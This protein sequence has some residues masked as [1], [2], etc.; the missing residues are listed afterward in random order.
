MKWKLTMLY[1]FHLRNLYS[2]CLA[3]GLIFISLI[4]STFAK[5]VTTDEA[6]KCRNIKCIRNHIDV[7]NDRILALLAERTAYVKRA[8]I[9]KGPDNI[10]NYSARV[11][12]ELLIIKKKSLQQNV[13]E[14]ISIS[15]F[16]AIIQSSI[17]YQR[18][19]VAGYFKNKN[20]HV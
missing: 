2:A 16:T 6:T 13:P 3:I 17:R 20:R 18:D 12:E 9:I 7:I 10:D 5:T 19:Y 15:T 8:G 1:F 4:S 11:R 14:E